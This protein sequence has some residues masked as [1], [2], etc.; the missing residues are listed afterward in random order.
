MIGVY[1]RSKSVYDFIY[2]YK[3][4]S[5]VICGKHSII[6]PVFNLNKQKKNQIN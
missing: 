5:L 4:T 2:C 3:N 6:V 1:W